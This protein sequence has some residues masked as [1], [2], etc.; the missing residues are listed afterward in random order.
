MEKDNSEQILTGA[1]SLLRGL[2]RHGVDFLFSNAGTDFPTIIEELA[3]IPPDEICVALTIPHETA[4]V[5]MAHG[6]FLMTGRPQ[7]VM[8]HVNV[9]LANAVMG[10]IN[11]A[12]DNIPVLV[13]SGRTPITEIGRPGSRMTPIQYGQEMFDQSSIIKDVVKYLS[14]IHI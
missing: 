7:A 10:A 6:Y 11:A 8:V 14:L 12:S 2:K 9:G 3:R 5:G 4:T 1:E 13:M